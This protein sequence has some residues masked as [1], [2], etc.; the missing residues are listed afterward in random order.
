MAHE[1][2]REVGGG[3]KTGA[4]A[5]TSAAKQPPERGGKGA[6]ALGEHG[7]T[8]SSPRAERTQRPAFGQQDWRALEPD[9][10]QFCHK[11]CHS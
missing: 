9:L 7:L 4:A 1:S 6:A 10:M 3:G 8:S 2:S 11:V 5:A